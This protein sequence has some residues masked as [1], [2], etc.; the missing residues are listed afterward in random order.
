MYR[1][2][3]SNDVG[4][5]DDYFT[6]FYD[7]INPDDEIIGRM[8]TE[9]DAAKVVSA[10]NDFYDPGSEPDSGPISSGIPCSLSGD[11]NRVVKL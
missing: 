11:S 2:S 4:P 1:Y 9:S 10:L 3:Y 7:I 6:E 8:Y 5:K